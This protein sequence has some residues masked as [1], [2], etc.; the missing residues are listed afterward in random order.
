MSHHDSLPLEIIFGALVLGMVIKFLVRRRK[1]VTCGKKVLA[2]SRAG[3]CG[4]CIS[5]AARGLHAQSRILDHQTQ[6]RR[7][8]KDRRR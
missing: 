2:R 4:D 8:Y 7:R 6:M 5:T 1:C 3:R